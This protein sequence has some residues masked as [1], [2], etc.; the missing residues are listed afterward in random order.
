MAA[1][2]GGFGQAIPTTLQD[3][4][5]LPAKDPFHALVG[6]TVDPSAN[7]LPQSQRTPAPAASSTAADPLAALADAAAIQP[8]TTATVVPSGTPSVA[9]ATA[10]AA[11]VTPPNAMVVSVDGVRE[12]VR[13]DAAFPAADPLFRLVALGAKGVRVAVYAG[14]FTSG[15]PTIKLLPRHTVKLVNEADGSRV[16]LRL[17]R[18]AVAS[19][20]AVATDPAAA[21]TDTTQV[22]VTTPSGS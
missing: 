6:T 5:R 17:L 4:S 14:S 7:E 20:A 22:T 11:P 8:P 21:S 3:F 9:A 15:A 10:E 16:V 18:L 13:V 12:T 19:D 2:P 1:T